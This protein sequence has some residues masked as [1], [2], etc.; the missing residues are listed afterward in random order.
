ML[1][2][3]DDDTRWASGDR[4]ALFLHAGSRTRT[5]SAYQDRDEDDRCAG[6]EDGRGVLDVAWL[7]RAYVSGN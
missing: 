4:V 7:V 3:E 1:T 5:G 2:N 6:A